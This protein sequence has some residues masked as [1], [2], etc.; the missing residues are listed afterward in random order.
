MQIVEPP[1]FKIIGYVS[2]DKSSKIK[3]KPILRMSDLY[4]STNS[5]VK[6]I[7]NHVFERQIYGRVESKRGDGGVIMAKTTSNAAQLE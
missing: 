6:R 5:K 3:R 4:L 2:T 1:R 7:I